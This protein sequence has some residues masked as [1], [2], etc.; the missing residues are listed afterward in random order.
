MTRWAAPE[1]VAIP[2]RVL[3]RSQGFSGLEREGEWQA[4]LLLLRCRPPDEGYADIHCRRGSVWTRPTCH[5]PHGRT[6][7]GTILPD[8][9][10]WRTLQACEPAT[11]SGDDNRFDAGFSLQFEAVRALLCCH[12]RGLASPRGCG[13][14][15]TCQSAVRVRNRRYSICEPS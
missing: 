4:P 1:C 12:D 3:H 5:R 10:N 7:S 2:T 11:R 14:S 9:N 13:L 8:N 15:V 6:W